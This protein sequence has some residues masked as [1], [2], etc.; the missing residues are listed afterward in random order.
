SVM[1][2][3]NKSLPTKKTQTFSALK[4]K[5]IQ[6]LEGE[7][8]SFACTLR[9]S[10]VLCEVDFTAIND[11]EVTVEISFDVNVNGILQVTVVDETTREMKQVTIES[12]RLPALQI[13]RMKGDIKSYREIGVR[14]KQRA[15]SKIALENYVYS[16]RNNLNTRTI[17]LKRSIEVIQAAEHETTE[18][19]HWLLTNRSADKE[20]FDAKRQK[21]EEVVNSIDI[22]SNTR[23]TEAA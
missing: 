20:E 23:A 7:S 14:N 15:E 12:R 6:V 22:Q 1:I 9:A 17:E 11:E 10:R 13:D 2:P 8:D 5:R 18:T 16:V 3:R 21:L 19:L 4:T